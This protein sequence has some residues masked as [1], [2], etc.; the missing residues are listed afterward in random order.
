MVAPV[1][2]NKKHYNSIFEVFDKNKLEEISE[3]EFFIW[4]MGL[5]HREIGEDTIN[6]ASLYDDEMDF[7]Y[8]RSLVNKY[9]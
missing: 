4:V 1:S 5:S 8:L 6:S 7:D 3:E 9:K 2:L